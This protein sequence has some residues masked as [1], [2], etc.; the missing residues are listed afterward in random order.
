[1]NL[2]GVLK[3]HGFTQI[4]NAGGYK[5]LASTLEAVKKMTYEYSV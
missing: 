5:D 3:A 4:L 1:M 2:K